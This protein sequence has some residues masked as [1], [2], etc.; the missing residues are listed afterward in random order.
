MSS[1]VPQCVFGL[2]EL[3]QYTFGQPQVGNDYFAKYVTYQP[4]GNFRVTHTNDVVPK[5]PGL[6]GYKH[7]GP[8]YHIT[9]GDNKQVSASDISVVEGLPLLAGNMATLGVSILAHG[10]YFNSIAACA[11]GGLP[12]F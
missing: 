6:P 11:P 3:F 7:W 1:K 4:G 10:W 2:T 8:E 9:S 5:L 12:E